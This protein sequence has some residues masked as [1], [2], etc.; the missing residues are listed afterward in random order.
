VVETGG[1][2]N[3]YIAEAA[4]LFAS[5]LIRFVRLKELVQKSSSAAFVNLSEQTS[6]HYQF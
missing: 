5:L 3:I 4:F 6:G 1:A 2:D